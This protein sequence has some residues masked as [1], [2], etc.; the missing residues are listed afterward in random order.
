MLSCDPS[1]PHRVTFRCQDRVVELVKPKAE[2]FLPAIVRCLGDDTLTGF[3]INNQ[4]E[5]FT[6]IRVLATIM[7]ALAYTHNIEFSLTPHYSKDAV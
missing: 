3:E 1:Q 4:S 5:S 2:E 6:T 7:N